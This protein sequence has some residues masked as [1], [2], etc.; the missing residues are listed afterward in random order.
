[1]NR[2]KAEGITSGHLHF[3]HYGSEC[4]GHNHIGPDHEIT[5]DRRVALRP[6][7]INIGDI[8]CNSPT[9]IEK[10]PKLYHNW[11]LIFNPKEAEKLPKH[12][13]SDHRK[14]LIS[15]ED[16]LRMGP[17]YQLSLQEEK[18]LVEYL[19]KIRKKRRSD[20]PRA[21]SKVQSYSY[22]NQSEKD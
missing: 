2:H 3:P 12:K 21:Q 14:E 22:P 4:F 7:A 9:L 10:L 8:V 11:L 18:L 17:S 16:E 13:E 20:H 1:L 5:Y 6:D 15:S 19:E